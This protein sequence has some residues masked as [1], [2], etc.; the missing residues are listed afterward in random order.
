MQIAYTEALFVYS[1]TISKRHSDICIEHG[2][3]LAD[4]SDW[5]QA[6][7]IYLLGNA[8]QK[9]AS[10]F[11]QAKKW[12]MALVLAA[13][14]GSGFDTEHQRPRTR[15]QTRMENNESNSNSSTAPNNA[16]SVN[17]TPVNRRK[18]F[19][20][21]HYTP[22]NKKRRTNNSTLGDIP[23]ELD[24]GVSF[25]SPSA[26]DGNCQAMERLSFTGSKNTHNTPM[27]HGSAD[28]RSMT[29]KGYK[30][31]ELQS[32]RRREAEDMVDRYI[33]R[34]IRGLLDL[35]IP[36]DEGAKNAA[37]ALATS[38]SV[39]VEKLLSGG[40][41]QPSY[42]NRGSSNNSRDSRG[43]ATR[44]GGIDLYLN[45]PQFDDY[46]IG[47]L[48]TNPPE[49]KSKLLMLNDTFAIVEVK[50]AIQ[51]I[52]KAMP[53]LFQYTRGIYNEQYDRRFAW[54]MA[55][56]GKKVQAVFFGPNYALASD[57]ICVDDAS[58]RAKLVKLL[59]DW[60]FCESHRLGYD[61][62]ILHNKRL[63]YYEINVGS[64]DGPITYYS[65]GAVISAERLFSRHTRCFIAST[66]K[67]GHGATIEP[68][69]FI[70]YAWSEATEDASVDY[71]DEGRHLQ[72]ITKTIEAEANL[73]GKCPRY[74]SGG[75][76]M[77]NRRIGNEGIKAVEDTSRSILSDG[78][79]RQLDDDQ[80][81]VNGLRVHKVICM[82]GVGKP[83]KELENV[84]EVICVMADA[85]ECHWEIYQRCKILHRDISTNNI[86]FSGRGSKIKGML[87]DF[88]HAIC[89]DDKDAVRHFE[90]TRTLP[91]MS[92]NNLEGGK[93]EHSLL[94]DWESLLYILCWVG[95]YGWKKKN[96]P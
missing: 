1:P 49:E 77:I 44:H 29:S 28:S 2:D 89:E 9:A 72:N 5:A 78:I 31:A 19:N 75:R 57:T 51:G 79:C 58:G 62:A 33:K 84:F 25:D 69:I 60:S 55:V 17:M 56:G 52:G 4:T 48:I 92:I 53:Q 71:R 6:A 82:K 18:L 36:D 81:F 7:A 38:I 43:A 87:V 39:L 65:K 22:P 85:M 26:G 3:H 64:K 32:M 70:K 15:L 50:S 37:G 67:P 27:K 66:A 13:A 76:V 47:T 46:T 10:A 21:S 35:A 61:P 68:E 93:L 90:R 86:L 91:F 95:T 74:Q 20:H 16:S 23:E 73:D 94:D 14:P 41:R 88:D 11:V 96:E 12:R 8:T 45:L 63:R 80:D 30:K 54:G 34:D 83:L 59:V 24:E 40:N 42:R